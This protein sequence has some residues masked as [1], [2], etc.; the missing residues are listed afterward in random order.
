VATSLLAPCDCSESDHGGAHVLKKLAC[1]KK[2]IV[3]DQFQEN[4]SLCS[5][6]QAHLGYPQVTQGGMVGQA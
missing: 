1:G 4:R 6:L 2:M 3:S 5:Y